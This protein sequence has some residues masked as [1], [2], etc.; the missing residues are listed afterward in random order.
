MGLPHWHLWCAWL[1]LRTFWV[2]N[3]FCRGKERKQELMIEE[4]SIEEIVM[5]SRK[6]AL[7][8]ETGFVE[9]VHGVWWHTGTQWCQRTCPNTR[10][11]QSNQPPDRSC[12]AQELEGKPHQFCSVISK[13]KGTKK[14]LCTVLPQAWWML[15]EHWLVHR[16]ERQ[17]D[18]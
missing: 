4:S 5:P 17:K 12:C 9:Q 11:W 6:R 2:T 8:L 10:S 3:I 7:W 18:G 1:I 14:E 16:R 15:L 13:P